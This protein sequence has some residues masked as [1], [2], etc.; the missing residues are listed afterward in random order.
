[1]AVK[2]FMRGMQASMTSF[3]YGMRTGVKMAAG[4]VGMRAWV[5]SI[6]SKTNPAN[7]IFST[8]LLTYIN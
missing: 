4:S 5:I 2:D 6:N 3:F 8:N 1:M 7:T